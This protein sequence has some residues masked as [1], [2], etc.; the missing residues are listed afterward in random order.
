MESNIKTANRSVPHVAER[1]IGFVMSRTDVV[2][3]PGRQSKIDALMAHLRRKP[4]DGMALAKVQRLM[5]RRWTYDDTLKLWYS[6]PTVS[7]LASRPSPF[8]AMLR[9]GGT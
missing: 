9:K 2:H 8:M 6:A 3:P 4:R 1:R 5:G 7:A